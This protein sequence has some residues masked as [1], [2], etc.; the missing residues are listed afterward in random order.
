M[1][2][3][4]QAGNFTLAAG[5]LLT[6][7]SLAHFFLGYPAV[8]ETIRAENAG[9]ETAQTLRVIWIFSSITM[10]A[11]G[12]WAVFLSGDLKTGS[13]RARMQG[14]M[15]GTA[16]LLFAAVGQT[17]EFPNYHLMSFGVI[18]LLVLLPL[19][20]SSAAFRNAG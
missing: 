10:C 18:G 4:K 1:K 9:P 14:L 3:F 11:M 5:I 8:N 6:L 15:W 16:L 20:I 7:A 17:F 2:K 13:R 12:L 19:L